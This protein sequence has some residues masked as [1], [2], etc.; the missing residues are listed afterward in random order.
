MSPYRFIKLFSQLI[1]FYLKAKTVHDLDSPFLYKL[2]KDVFENRIDKSLYA[3]IE[4]R[5]NQ[6]MNDGTELVRYDLG[7]GSKHPSAETTVKA[8][9][10]AS[11]VSPYHGQLLNR[12]SRSFNP[13]LILELGTAVGISG[14]YLI[15]GTQSKLITIEGDPTIANIAKKTFSVTSGGQAQI[16]VDSF[17][18]ALES[19]QNELQ[20][21]DM[22]YIDGDHRAKSIHQYLQRIVPLCSPRHCIILDD[23]RWNDDMFSYW[24]SLQ[25]DAR[26]NVKI[27]LFRQG[28]LIRNDDIQHSVHLSLIKHRYKLFNLGLTR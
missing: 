28:L 6:L 5:R 17:Q 25:P 26:W 27:D 8:F 22:V 24:T 20:H 9:T 13:S 2:A 14:S 10:A 12:L 1:E 15:Q 3:S 16:I 21:V 19:N 7:T 23:I 4:S 18:H 11:S